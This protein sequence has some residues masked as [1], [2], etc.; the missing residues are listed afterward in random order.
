MRFILITL[1]FI[2]PLGAA[3]LTDQDKLVIR[4]SQIALQAAQVQ[5][6]AAEA[7]LYKAQIALNQRESMTQVKAR[8]LSEKI[9]EIFDR[10]ELDK[11][12]FA[13][14]ASTLEVV[15]KKDD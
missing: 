13:L 12:K 5:Q 15:E 1:M 14:D 3:E 8:E 9:T 6:A 4:E 11:A 2:L 7:E 10:L